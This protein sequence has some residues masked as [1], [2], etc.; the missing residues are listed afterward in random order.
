[1]AARD[2]Q[3][4]QRSA[5]QGDER[6]LLDNTDV[7]VSEIRQKAQ[8]Q[9]A[10]TVG[11]MR[12]WISNNRHPIKLVIGGLR[13]YPKT[14]HIERAALIK[15]HWFLI[16]KNLD[17]TYW[18]WEAS[19][20]PVS[21][22]QQKFFPL[23]RKIK[24]ANNH[25]YQTPESAMCGYYVIVLAN[26]MLDRRNNSSSDSEY[27]QWRQSG[28]YEKCFSNLDTFLAPQDAIR[29]YR[30]IKNGG[31]ELFIN[32]ES[33]KSMYDTIISSSQ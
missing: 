4:D 13:P 16:W 10:L 32:D 7:A 12:A 28:K 33:V 18:I 17:D 9:E 25:I 5:I 22:L 29:W 19:G 30:D 24:R 8:L 23:L 31:D 3:I 14:D 15:G 26:Y 2:A 11:N 6:K 21:V 20:M 1:M 27:L